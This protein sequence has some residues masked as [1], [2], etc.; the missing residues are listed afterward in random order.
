MWN[1]NKIHGAPQIYI[2]YFLFKSLFCLFF[3]PWV[4]E[5]VVENNEGEKIIGCY[6]YNN[7]NY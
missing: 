2:N 3:N 7:K 5:K 4:T 6:D 1:T